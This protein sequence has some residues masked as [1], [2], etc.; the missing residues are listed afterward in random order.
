MREFLIVTLICIPLITHV[1]QCSHYSFIFFFK[2]I[3]CTFGW[4]HFVGAL[5]LPCFW[6]RVS[7]LLSANVTVW[8]IPLSSGWDYRWEPLHLN[9]YMGSRDQSEAQGKRFY[10][11][12]HL[13]GPLYIFFI[14]MSTQRSPLSWTTKTKQNKNQQQQN[15]PNKQTVLLPYVSNLAIVWCEFIIFVY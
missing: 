7:F 10:P 6:G 9:F 12:G 5:L 11:L 4:G 15:Q 8:T 14:K 3:M 13:A 1:K 2:K